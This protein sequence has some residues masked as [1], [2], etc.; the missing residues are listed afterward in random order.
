MELINQKN[1][2]ALFLNIEKSFLQL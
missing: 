1:I 2:N